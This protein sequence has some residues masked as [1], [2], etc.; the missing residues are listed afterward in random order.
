VIAAVVFDLDGVL[1]QSEPIWEEVRRG[2]VEEHG[3]CWAADAQNRL[4]GMSTSEWARYLSEDLGVGLPAAQV[5][6]VVIAR[7]AVRLSAHLPLLPGA[8]RAVRLLAARWPLALASS[9]PRSLIDLVLGESGLAELFKVTISTEEVSRGK[10]APDVYLEAA[11][12]LGAQ[13]A[14]CAAVE[15]STNGVLSA[16]AA[17]LAVVAVPQG[18]YPVDTSVLRDASVVLEDLDDLTPTVIESIER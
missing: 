14:S 9:S 8:S 15:D 16:L 1:V 7:M 6:E 5:A 11:A 3:G 10:P 17:G 12:R 4:M 2:L 13:P 18:R